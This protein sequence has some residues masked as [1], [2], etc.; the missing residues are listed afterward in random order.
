MSLMLLK[1]EALHIFGSEHLKGHVSLLLIL[2]AVLLLHLLNLLMLS[3]LDSTRVLLFGVVFLLQILLILSTL[4]AALRWHLPRL[5][6]V[7]DLLLVTAF[8]VLLALAR[9]SIEF[10]IGF[11]LA[12][13]LTNL[14]NFDVIV[15]KFTLTLLREERCFLL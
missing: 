8:L 7:L 10:V 5:C 12:G 15:A 6:L 4:L 1:V 11:V 13:L 9:L 3:S 14:N 2:I